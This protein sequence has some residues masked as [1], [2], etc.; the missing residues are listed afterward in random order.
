VQRIFDR[1]IACRENK[2]KALPNGL[3][4][5]LPMRK[6]PWVD[7]SI[8]IVLGLPRS[9]RGR[10]YMFIVVVNFYKIA[11]FISYHKTD[12]TTNVTDFFF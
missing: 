8:D 3:Y 5:S 4:T 9:K 12:D 6:E 7:I 1:R 11:H 10:D 2:S